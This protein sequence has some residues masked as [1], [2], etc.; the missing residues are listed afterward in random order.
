MKNKKIFMY[1]GII[2]ALI[3]VIALGWIV[4]VNKS[5]KVKINE[6][7]TPEEEITSK[8][9]RQ[10]IVTLYFMDKES[11]ELEPEARQI[12][13]IMLLE[14]P[15]KVLINMLI[16]GPKNEQLIGL[17]PE[18]T[19]LN[20]IEISEGIVYI[21][22]SEEFIKGNIKGKEEEMQIVN[23]ILKTLV[24]L[25]EV[26]GI[27]IQ[28]NGEEEAAFLDKEVNFNETFYIK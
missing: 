7:I 6:E 2:M 18:G 3:F 10:T 27:K 17:I 15:Y 20:S 5:E 26:R 19:K 25:S 24:E 16:E 28:I 22:F 9:M 23:S 1:V 21:D 14:N 4:N 12:D 11:F 8:Q 13:S